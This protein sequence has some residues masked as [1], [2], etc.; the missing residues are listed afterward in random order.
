[1]N[2]NNVMQNLAVGIAGGIFS[3][4]IVSVVFYIL[5]EFQ[6][7][8][9]LAKDMTHQL[10]G[11]IALEMTKYV[12]ASKEFDR[13]KTAKSFYIETA[14]NFARFEPWKFRYEIKEIMCEF[15][16]ILTDGK[17][18]LCEWDDEI[19]SEV[20]KRIRTNLDKLEQCEKKFAFGFL[21]RVFRNKI[22]F[23]SEVVFIAI[24]F[25]A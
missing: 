22:V 1:M 21:K 14:N 7:E 17:Y 11:V 23:A 8:L 12:K 6:N 19:F 9:N 24:V 4:I 25:I 20:S 13:K 10:Y 18:A 3:S 16:E 15:N 2:F 5:N